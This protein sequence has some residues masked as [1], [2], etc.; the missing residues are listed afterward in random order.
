MIEH[1]ISQTATYAASY[2]AMGESVLVQLRRDSQQVRV[3][4]TPAQARHFA[5]LIPAAADTAE[6]K[7]SQALA[8]KTLR[9]VVGSVVRDALAD[10]E[11]HPCDYNNEL[12]RSREL[13]RR[14]QHSMP[15]SR[16]R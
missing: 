14:W 10:V 7:L 1:T 12:V 11:V 4:M 8:S 2:A 13:R 6:N 3:A 9:G 16:R 5:G 15:R